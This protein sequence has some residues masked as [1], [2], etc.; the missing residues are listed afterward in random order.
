VTAGIR[1]EQEVGLL[2]A[3]RLSPGGLSPTSE[4]APKALL[5]ADMV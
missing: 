2:F 1:D 5:T 3:R 4:H